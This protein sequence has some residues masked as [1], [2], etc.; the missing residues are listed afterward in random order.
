MKTQP[1]CVFRSAILGLQH[2]ADLTCQ[3]KDNNLITQNGSTYRRGNKRQHCDWYLTQLFSCIV[4]M[5]WELVHKTM[6]K[7]GGPSIEEQVVDDRD[8][9]K[10]MIRFVLNES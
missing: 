5:S 6:C 10:I 9:A 4:N 7:G 3:H 1:L 8:D 2:T